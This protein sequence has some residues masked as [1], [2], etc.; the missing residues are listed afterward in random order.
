MDE[1]CVTLSNFHEFTSKQLELLCG[2][3]RQFSESINM[4]MA[5]DLTN[6]AA[7]I[8]DGLLKLSAACHATQA[9]RGW[10]QAR[11]E[12]RPVNEGLPSAN[13]EVVASKCACKLG[14][15][16]LMCRSSNQRLCRH[17]CGLL[18]A[19][20]AL[21]YIEQP[22]PIFFRRAGSTRFRE[23]AQH[24]ELFPSMWSDPALVVKP[25]NRTRS[26]ILSTGTPSLTL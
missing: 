5:A 22:P 8:E 23:F 3:R 9:Q 26:I 12:V 20:V 19:S 2:N 13:L 25:W 17:K 24:P 16:E 18:A 10:Y 15:S 4:V 1:T 11:V 6:F 14:Y 7:T 21:R